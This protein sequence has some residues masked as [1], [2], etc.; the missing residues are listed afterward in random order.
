MF[1][2]HVWSLWQA[3]SGGGAGASNRFQPPIS[4]GFIRQ[5]MLL[6]GPSTPYTIIFFILYMLYSLL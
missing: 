4:R 2:M 3:G 6:V 5:H 1:L